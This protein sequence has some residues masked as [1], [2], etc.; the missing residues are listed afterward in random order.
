[1]GAIL[2]AQDFNISVF[3]ATNCDS[4]ATGISGVDV[5]VYPVPMGAAVCSGATDGTGIFSCDIA[6]G[7]ASG[8]NQQWQVWIFD[9]CGDG[10]TLFYDI[11]NNQGMITSWGD[12]ICCTDST[13]LGINN[14]TNQGNVA[15][16]YPNPVNNRLYIHPT[17]SFTGVAIEYTVYDVNGKFIKQDKLNGDSIDL[18][19]LQTGSY[20]LQL[21]SEETI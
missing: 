18:S 17:K 13:T 4:S 1:M 8:P 14:L 2:F 6:G 20:I 9:P 19:E 15:T 10:D 5:I 16:M 3:V 11:Q 7:G 12:T 21:M